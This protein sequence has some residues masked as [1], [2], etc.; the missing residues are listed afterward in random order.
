MKPEKIVPLLLLTCATVLLA[1]FLMWHWRL[2]IIR[3]FDVDEYAHLHWASRIVMG[4]KPFT[5]YLS[6]FPPLFHFLL[7]PLVAAGWGTTDPFIY[8]RIFIFVTFTVTAMISI[9]LFWEMRRKLWAAVAAGAILAFLPLPFDKY[10]EIRPDLPATM[11]TLAAVYFQVRWFKYRRNPDAVLSG[12]GYSLSVLVL[13]K[14]V[15]NAGLGALMALLYAYWRAQNGQRGQKTIVTMRRIIIPF[16]IGAG[17]PIL[18]FVTYLLSIGDIGQVWYSLTKLPVEANRISKYFIMMPDLFFYPNGIY[19][20]LD[21]WNRGLIT[22]HVI[23]VFGLL[24]GVHRLLLPKLGSDKQGMWE[25]LLVAG[26]F[27]V[28][29]I[30]YVAI[31]PLK[32]AQ[33]LIPIGVFVAWYAADGLNELNVWLSRVRV[34]PLLFLGLSALGTWY[35]YTVFDE[36][37][38][39]KQYWTNT[40]G[41]GKINAM[42]NK[43]PQKEPVLDLDGRMLYNPDPYFACCIPFGQFAEFLSRPLP[44]LPETLAR[45]NTKFINQ[46]ELGRVNTLPWKDQQYIYANYRSSGGNNSLLI[47]N[48]VTDF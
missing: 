20:G 22:N 46:G 12:I 25:E 19:Y 1:V 34:G 17:L 32:H 23:W 31:V 30:F 33:Y 9:L 3:Y 35:L 38:F 16:V 4:V 43:I 21:G 2:G 6:F 8:S 41:L 40:D 15:P 48:D 13:T 7:A 39:V 18:L 10:L 47:R 26:Q 5:G 14:M 24:L 29:V 42:Y 44:D 45:T 36:S 27:L 37:A 11:L 28:Q